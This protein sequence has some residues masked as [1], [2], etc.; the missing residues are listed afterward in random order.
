MKTKHLPA[1]ILPLAITTIFVLPL[2]WVFFASLQTLGQLPPRELEWFPTP[3]TFSNYT[4]LFEILPFGRYLVNSLFTGTS[5]MLITLLTAS[6][7][8]LGM[9]LLDQRSRLRLLILSLAVQII[10]VTAVWLTR[11]LFFSKIGISNSHFAL[12]APAV[13]GTS[14]LFILLFYWSFRR[15]DRSVFESVELDGANI[16]QTW[17]HIALPLARPALMAVGMLSFLYY[18]ND[19]INPLLYLRSQTLYTLPIGLLQLQELDKT[20]WSLLMT[21]SVVVTLPALIVF[22]V[23]QRSLLWWDSE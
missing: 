5:G 19:F 13:M 3:V 21:A 9:S 11:F 15:I 17:W 20:N 1:Q 6:W 22:S 12:I 16:I 7:A 2:I 14:S 18:W 8:G 4:R 23:L 10:P